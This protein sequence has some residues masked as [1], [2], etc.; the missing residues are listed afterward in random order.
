MDLP[1]AWLLELRTGGFASGVCLEWLCHALD[2]SVADLNL[3]ATNAVLCAFSE[4][5]LW[6]ALTPP[7]VNVL[8]Q[9]PAQACEPPG[10]LFPF[11]HTNFGGVVLCFLT[12]IPLP[13]L[14]CLHRNA[15]VD[16][17]FPKNISG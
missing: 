3:Y 7:Q 17:R 14:C 12:M 15:A 11:L 13:S 1:A 2:T 4:G 16:Y 9:S 8:G 10:E 5:S 6:Q